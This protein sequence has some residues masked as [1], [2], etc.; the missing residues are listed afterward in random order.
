MTDPNVESRDFTRAGYGALLDRFR[1]LGYAAVSY[2]AADP[3][4]HHLILRHD[5]DMSIQ[6]ALPLAEVEAER[7]MQAHYF[8]LLRTEMYNPWSAAGRRD[9]LRLAA[10]GHEVGLHFDASLYPDDDAAVDAAVAHECAT[11]EA[12]LDGKVALVS[13]HRPVR[14]LQGREGM[15]GG[16]RHAY[17]PRF[18]SEMGYCSDSR[19]GWHHGH[20]LDHPA[21]K[22]GHALQLLTHP[23]W[24]SGEAEDSV[25]VTLDRFRRERD[26]LLADELAANCSAYPGRRPIVHE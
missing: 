26:L 8:V 19:G 22:S 25:V 3:T 16:R 24:W 9:L 18:F 10:F 23:I 12:L 6:A 20:P 7:G 15:V 17:E 21:V 2:A 13:F 1:E 5:I 11:L 4:A 14:H